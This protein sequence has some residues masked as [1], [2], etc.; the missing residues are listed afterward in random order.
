MK[1]LRTS[2][3]NR[4]YYSLYEERNTTGPAM[5]SLIDQG[6][7]LVGK[8]GAVQFA[9]G[10]SPRADW[11]DF[12]CPFNP[13]ISIP[14]LNTSKSV[15][16]IYIDFLTSVS[17][18]IRNPDHGLPMASSR[19]AIFRRLRHKALRSYPIHKPRS[20][21]TLESRQRIWKVRI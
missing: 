3:G 8:M 19:R 18:A 15:A 20:S 21:A 14:L 7:V 12:Y 6:A 5:Q 1:D 4:A 2:G 16:D 9:N 10:D 17:L 13:R 11:V